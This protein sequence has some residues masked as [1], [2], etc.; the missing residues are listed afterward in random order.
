[1]RLL[2][3]DTYQS[4]TDPVNAPN[5]QL[6]A[7]STEPIQLDFSG[8]FG[9]A[10]I[11]GN[12]D[13]FSFALWTDGTEGETPLISADNVGGGEIALDAGGGFATLT[14]S[15]TQADL[16]KRGTYIAQC[17]A[18]DAATLDWR[19]SERFHVVVSQGGAPR[20]V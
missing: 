11:L 13:N 20:P 19:A 10:R 5:L 7:G 16:L 8:A 14:L 15:Q 4:T 18:R 17:N 9:D 6:V 12:I 3:L 2:F 1:M